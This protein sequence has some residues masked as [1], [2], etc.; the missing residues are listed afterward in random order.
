MGKAKYVRFPAPTGVN[1]FDMELPEKAMLYAEV[2]DGG[3]YIAAA[4]Q[5]DSPMRKM[6]INLVEDGAEFEADHFVDL[7]LVTLPYG[8]PRRALILMFLPPEVK[9]QLR[10]QAAGI[11][12]ATQLPGH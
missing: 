2:I 11:I 12:G 6:T 9:A 10:A 8:A 1:E 5:A 4:Q 7:G 3:L